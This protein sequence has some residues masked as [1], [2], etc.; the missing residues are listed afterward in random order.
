MS[1]PQGTRNLILSLTVGCG[2]RKSTVRRDIPTVLQQIV[3]N[4]NGRRS[5]IPKASKKKRGK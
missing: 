2:W 3:D 4:A 1:M 5:M